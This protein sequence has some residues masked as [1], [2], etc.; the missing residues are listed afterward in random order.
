MEPPKATKLIP[1]QNFCF[2]GFMIVDEATDSNNSFIDSK[3]SQLS[4]RLDTLLISRLV[5]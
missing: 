1:N 5:L 3:L 4:L 2:Y